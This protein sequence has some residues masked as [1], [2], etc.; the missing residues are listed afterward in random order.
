ML[1][2]SLVGRRMTLG[3]QQNGPLATAVVRHSD[4]KEPTVL[5]K[6]GASVCGQTRE[7][8]KR[9]E[10]IGTKRKT[11]KLPSNEGRVGGDDTEFMKTEDKASAEPSSSQ[12]EEKLERDVALRNKITVSRVEAIHMVSGVPEEHTTTRYVRIWKPSKSATQSGTADTKL[13]RLEFET[14]ERWENPLIGWTSSGDPLSNTQAEFSTLEE[15]VNFAEKNGWDFFIER[16]PSTEVR[17]KFRPGYEANFSW[18]RRT[19]GSTK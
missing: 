6:L 2:A 8:S 7:T 19:R 10:S 16:P 5:S 12:Q 14:R 11:N 17:S 3:Q 9:S 4:S 18:N 1:V 15:A 13:W